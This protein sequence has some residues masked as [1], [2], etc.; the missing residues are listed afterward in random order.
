MNVE[1]THLVSISACVKAHLYKTVPPQFILC[2]IYIFSDIGGR[3]SQVMLSTVSMAFAC[4]EPSC[5]KARLHA[6]EHLA[7]SH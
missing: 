1:G 6:E 7:Q 2:I 5:F 3:S 4:A